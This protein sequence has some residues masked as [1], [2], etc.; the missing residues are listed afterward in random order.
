MHLPLLKEANI[1]IFYA[2]VATRRNVPSGS[3][4]RGDESW[5]IDE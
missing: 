2:A 1:G 5:R 4:Y 3:Q